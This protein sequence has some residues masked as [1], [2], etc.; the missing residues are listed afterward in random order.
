M[1]RRWG[2]DCR[3]RRGQ[4]ETIHLL[5]ETFH[6]LLCVSESQ[7]HGLQQTSYQQSV[8]RDQALLRFVV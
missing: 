4:A 5:L 6:L 1:R 7:E 2:R 8:G 3:G